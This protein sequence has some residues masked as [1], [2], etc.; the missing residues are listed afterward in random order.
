[1]MIELTLNNGKKLLVNPRYLQTAY[2]VT[3][4][5]CFLEIEGYGHSIEVTQS[6]E[7]IKT[8]LQ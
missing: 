6:I 8:L 4:G 5:H 3:N 2:E 7:T 1:M